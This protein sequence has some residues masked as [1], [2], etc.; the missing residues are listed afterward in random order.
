MNIMKSHLIQCRSLAAAVLCLAAAMPARAIDAA[1]L[2]A[3]I[4]A[5]MGTTVREAPCDTLGHFALPHPYSVPCIRGGFQ[6]MFY[7]DT[8]FT[9][10]GLLADGD[11]AQAR[12]NIADIAAMVDR[13]GYMP[14]AT[15]RDLL[16]R[17]QPPYLALMLDDYLTA[18]ADTAFLRATLPSVEREY[19]FWM[20]ERMTPVGLNRYGHSATDDELVAFRDDIGPRVGIDPAAPATRARR[21]AEG[22]H[23]LAEAESGWDF[24]PRFE[25]RCMDYCPVDLNSLLYAYETLIPKFR[26]MLGLPGTGD[27]AARADRRRGLMGRLMADP[28]TGLLLDYDFVNGRLSPV[29]SAASFWPL[30]TGVATRVEAEAALRA[31]GRLEAPHGIYTCDPG[32]SPGIYQ[33]DAPNG[34]A[35]CQYAAYEGLR[36]YGFD[37]DARRIARK[38]VDSIVRIYDATG[39]LWEKYNAAEGNVRVQDEY[40]MPGEFMG[41][42]AGVFRHAHDYLESS[43]EK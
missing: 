31:L 37:A 39:Q 2:S 21:L 43:S 35:A 42:T 4:K 22:A 15:H 25:R 38:Y 10:L 33:W 12:N 30:L 19:G 7:W 13:F 34:W 17:S 26:S 1:G 8:Y 32:L 18:T 14:N 6:D 23:L 28:A 27:W 3:R 11:F 24:N 29:V 20:R 16:N 41:W 5:T 36:R 9:N 40:P